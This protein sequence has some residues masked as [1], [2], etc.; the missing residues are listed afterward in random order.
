MPRA[1]RPGSAGPHLGSSGRSRS[2]RGRHPVGVRVAG[3]RA[4]RTS[5]KRLSPS[6]TVRVG[7]E[8]FGDGQE[9]G[10]IRLHHRRHRIEHHIEGAGDPVLAQ[11]PVDMGGSLLLRSPM[12]LRVAS[13]RR[14]ARPLPDAC[15]N[16]R[17]ICAVLLVH[18]LRRF[19]ADADRGPTVTPVLVPRAQ[20][21]LV[22]LDKLKGANRCR[23]RIRCGPQQVSPVGRSMDTSPG[24]RTFRAPVG[25]ARQHPPHQMV[26]GH[27]VQAVLSEDLARPCD[28]SRSGKPAT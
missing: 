22:A 21:G 26:Q 9:G 25:G 4:G 18:D 6:V 20:S 17:V 15:G 24:P 28:R 5:I 7:S 19:T 23:C 13:A 14:E 10:A 16:V 8:T 11:P 27:K 1:R 2:P 3:T 12:R